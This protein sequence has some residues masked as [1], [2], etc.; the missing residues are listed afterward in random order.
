MS[1]APLNLNVIIKGKGFKNGA[2]AKFF[3]TGTTDPAGVNVKST[4]F[5]SS[6][7][8]IALV[9]IADAAKTTYVAAR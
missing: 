1:R 3:K 8:L 2:K 4:Q 9:D 6:T 7:Q 5:V